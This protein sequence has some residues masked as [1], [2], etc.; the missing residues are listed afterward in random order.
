MAVKDWRKVRREMLIDLTAGSAGGIAC[1]YAGQPFDT[2]KVKM[3]VSPHLY[4][5]T[6]QCLKE[7]SVKDGFRGFYAGATPALMAQI[8]ENSVIFL[9]YSQCQK[10]VQ[11]ATGTSAAELNAFHHACS[12]SLAAFLASFFL[13]PLEL[14]KCRL[15][16]AREFGTL[17]PGMG[18]L[19][20]MRDTFKA[21]GFLGFYNGFAATVAREMPGYFFF[22]GGYEATKYFL[23]STNDMKSE[24][25]GLL[26]TVIAGGMGGVSLWATIY[27]TDVIKSRSQVQAGASLGFLSLG[28]Q[29]V[30]EEGQSHSVPFHRFPT[31]N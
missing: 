26:K 25:Y 29:I 6:L 13:C 12:G 1:V 10:L 15:Q 14:I 28:K 4:R 30:R 23:A 16:T 2:I 19:S 8:G 21:D 27:P 22:F 20:V 17:K 11:V 18:P 9:C 5:S 31:V 3:Q 7:M 24:K